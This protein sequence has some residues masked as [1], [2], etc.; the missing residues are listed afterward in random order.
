[1]PRVAAGVRSSYGREERGSRRAV[2]A[3]EVRRSHKDRRERELSRREKERTTASSVSARQTTA[4]KKD[5]HGSTAN[6]TA[7]EVT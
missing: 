5:K 2:A 6:N 4:K 1:M 3:G 7:K